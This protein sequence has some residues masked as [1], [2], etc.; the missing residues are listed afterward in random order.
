MLAAPL[1]C[2]VY[3]HVCQL[4]GEYA[5]NGIVHRVR[6][7]AVSAVL[8]YDSHRLRAGILQFGVVTEVDGTVVTFRVVVIDEW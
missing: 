2:T 4:G 1:L 5:G 7:R 3:R 8:D 6:R